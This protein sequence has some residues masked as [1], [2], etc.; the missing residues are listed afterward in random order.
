MDIFDAEYFLSNRHRSKRW[1]KTRT[2]LR[3]SLSIPVLF[4]TSS[5]PWTYCK[6]KRLLTGIQ[7]L[8]KLPE[9][10]LEFLVAGISVLNLQ[11]STN[12]ETEI[13]VP[14]ALGFTGRQL[15]SQLLLN[16]TWKKTV[17][18]C[19]K[20]SYYWKQKWRWPSPCRSNWKRNIP[21]RC[22]SLC[23]RT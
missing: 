14:D 5:N 1:W 18:N 8:D 21:F 23:N 10:S 16:N 6:Q 20:I 11:D 9:R 17:L 4:Q 15:P 13:T 7:N 19:F 12:S 3:L 2:W 22:P